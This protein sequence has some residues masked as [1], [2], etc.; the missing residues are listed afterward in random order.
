MLDLSISL[1]SLGSLCYEPMLQKIYDWVKGSFALIL[2]TYT[3][4]R[5]F[6]DRYVMI[7]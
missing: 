1:G 7:P 6:G 3:H 4:F 5:D 2:G